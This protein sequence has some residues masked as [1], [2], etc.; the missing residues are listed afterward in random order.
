VVR[1]ARCGQ[2]NLGGLAVGGDAEHGAAV[3]ALS[4]RVVRI[5]ARVE[6]GREIAVAHHV[7]ECGD[8]ILPGV[9][10]R[11]AEAATLRNVDGGDRGRR[12][13]VPGAE[14]FE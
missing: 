13:L 7:A 8:S 10:Q 2:S 5:D 1:L 12:S 9:D 6:G 14:A 3:Q 11:A 4:C